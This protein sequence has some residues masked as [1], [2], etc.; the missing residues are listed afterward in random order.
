MYIFSPGNKDQTVYPSLMN[1]TFLNFNMSPLR[2]D[3]GELRIWRT[4]SD[5]F[6]Y[7][8]GAFERLIFFTMEHMNAFFAQ[9]RRNLKSQIFGV[10]PRE[11]MLKFRIDR[12]INSNIAA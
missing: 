1:G 3:P 5:N 6:L 12:Y 9:L 11:E 4:I 8:G 2:A 7:D 10:C